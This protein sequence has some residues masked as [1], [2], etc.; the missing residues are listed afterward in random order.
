M[1]NQSML[2]STETCRTHLKRTE[3]S[4]AAM[5]DRVASEGRRLIDLQLGHQGFPM[6]F[7]GFDADVYGSR[8]LL[9]G[10]SF[11]QQSEQLRLA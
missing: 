1:K 11:H 10:L 8:D 7:N 2:E 6:F 3:L 9:A 4:S 5:L